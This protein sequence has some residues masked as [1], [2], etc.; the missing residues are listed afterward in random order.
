[1]P[2]VDKPIH[3]WTAAD[4][5]Q[6]MK[7]IALEAALEAARLVKAEQAQPDP[8]GALNAQQAAKFLGWK[9]TKFHELL[10]EHPELDA[11]GIV[12]KIRKNGHKYRRW[13]VDGL[14][15]WQER[16]AQSALDGSFEA[17]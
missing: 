15:A 8:V 3:L 9:K 10:K 11:M 1:M 13:P 6:V 2:T 5:K 17:A 12:Y 7:G 16:R 4:F 14:K